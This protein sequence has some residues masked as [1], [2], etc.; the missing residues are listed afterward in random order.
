MAATK[1][2]AAFTW[3]SGSATTAGTTNPISTST[4]Y[5]ASVYV[6]V[7]VTGTGPTTSFTFIV[8]QSPDGTNWYSGPVFNAPLA[9]GTYYFGPP[10]LSLAP[11]CQSVQIVYTIEA[12]GTSPVSTLTAQLGYISGV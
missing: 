3:A 8:Q 4:Y 2:N 6:K 11:D 7:V 1:G 10:Q 9:A 12:G 5:A